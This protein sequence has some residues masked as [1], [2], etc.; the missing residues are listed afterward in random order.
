MDSPI[1]LNKNFH[2][3]STTTTT[4]LSFKNDEPSHAIQHSKREKRSGKKGGKK[5]KWR[6]KFRDLEFRIPGMHRSKTPF[7]LQ[8]RQRGEGGGTSEL[9]RIK[10]QMRRDSNPKFSGPRNT[11]RKFYSLFEKEGGRWRMEFKN[12]TAIP[13]FWDSRDKNGF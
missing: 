2:N 3:P 6:P 13:S 10:M 11:T 5:I 12:A 8:M 1:I 7:L 4:L 9:Y